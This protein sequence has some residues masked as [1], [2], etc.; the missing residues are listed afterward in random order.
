VLHALPISSSLTWSFELYLE[1]ST[2]Y[3]APHYV[4]T[5]YNVILYVVCIPHSDRNGSGRG[6]ES[7]YYPIITMWPNACPRTRFI[8]VDGTRFAQRSPTPQSRCKWRLPR[9]VITVIWQ[10]R[11]LGL[12]QKPICRAHAKSEEFPSRNQYVGRMQRAKHF[13]ANWRLLRLLLSKYWMPLVPGSTRIYDV[14]CRT[15]ETWISWRLRLSG[16]PIM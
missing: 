8:Y 5:Y 3:E 10:T 12:L 7:R 1:K 11:A 14:P 4:I 13:Q 6:F 9:V 16:L 2:S 15:K